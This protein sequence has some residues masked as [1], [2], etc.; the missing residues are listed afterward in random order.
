MCAH[1]ES[2]EAEDGMAA[3]YSEKVY[4]GIGYW[5]G[6]LVVQVVAAWTAAWRGRGRGRSLC[7]RAGGVGILL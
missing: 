1:V 5:S 3:Q 4:T 6:W 2:E 7:G